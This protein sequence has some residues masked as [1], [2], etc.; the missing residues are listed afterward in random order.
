MYRI[1]LDGAEHQAERRMIYEVFDGILA[2]YSMEYLL[3]LVWMCYNS[4]HIRSEVRDTVAQNVQLH[5]AN[6]NPRTGGN[7]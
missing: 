6:K 3:Q 4:T 7:Q 2:G 1:R 5:C